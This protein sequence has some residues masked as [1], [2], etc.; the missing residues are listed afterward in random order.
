MVADCSGNANERGCLPARG[1]DNG[2]SFGRGCHRSFG[3]AVVETGRA[4]DWREVVG[5]EIRVRGA[6]AV[7]ELS[8]WWFGV[9]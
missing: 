9:R 2:D 1:V 6:G 8:R 5:F 7:F 4:L 3:G